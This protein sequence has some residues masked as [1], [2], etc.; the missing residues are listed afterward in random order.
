MAAATIAN[1][2]FNPRPRFYRRLDAPPSLCVMAMRNMT[3][4]HLVTLIV[5]AAFV[6]LYPDDAGLI[7]LLVL[8]RLIWR[9]TS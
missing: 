2:G 7:F 9:W 1:C 4:F 6:W 3:S 5:G 8:A